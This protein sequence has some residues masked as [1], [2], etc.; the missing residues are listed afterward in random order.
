MPPP[1][2]IKE[3]NVELLIDLLSSAFEC[4]AKK[5]MFKKI[6]PNKMIGVVITMF[7]ALRPS[8]WSKRYCYN[9]K[10]T[11]EAIDKC[12][13]FFHIII[14]NMYK[15]QVVGIVSDVFLSHSHY[16]LSRVF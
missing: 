15:T 5:P 11:F 8:T 7:T 3:K 6:L 12:G 10:T 1:E 2:I 16:V 13:A 9:P 14:Y 4:D